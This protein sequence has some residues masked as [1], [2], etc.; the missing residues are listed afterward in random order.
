MTHT[1]DHGDPRQEQKLI[2][3]RAK[4]GMASTNP[5]KRPAPGMGGPAIT[6]KT[7]PP[8]SCG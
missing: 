4:S 7:P 6:G 8:P 5:Q 2:K 3:G 1:A